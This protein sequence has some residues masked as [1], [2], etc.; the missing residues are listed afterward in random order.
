MTNNHPS[1]SR[2]AFLGAVGAVGAVAA[3]AARAA[4]NPCKL[5]EKCDETWD[6]V[7]VGAGGA[8]MA[9]AVSAAQHGLAKILI[10]EK[11]GFVGGNT[12]LSGGG[13]NSYD[14]K[15][16]KAQGIEDS[17]QLHAEQMWRG[18]DC[19]GNRDLIRVMTEN[20]W[21]TVQWME[22]LGVTFPDK[23]IQV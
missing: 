8:G 19:R 12:L 1:V 2:R 16:Q 3:G 14:P 7:V 17:P 4:P 18:G 9:A 13:F 10:L 21:D 5:P 23:I 6:L 15:R 11:M 22:S 20:S